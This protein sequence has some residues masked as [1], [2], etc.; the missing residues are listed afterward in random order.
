MGEGEAWQEGNF[1]DRANIKCRF[2]HARG[3]SGNRKRFEC[4]II[5][6][7]PF[8]SCHSPLPPVAA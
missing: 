6:I 7:V 1:S 5:I 4:S 3:V 2:S 8:F